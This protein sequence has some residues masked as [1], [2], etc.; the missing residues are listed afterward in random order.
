V[1]TTTVADD[2]D[3]GGSPILDATGKPARRSSGACPRCGADK[4]KRVASGGFGTPHPVCNACGHE[5]F[6]EAWP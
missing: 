2:A 6:G 4:E 3:R 1:K 5:F